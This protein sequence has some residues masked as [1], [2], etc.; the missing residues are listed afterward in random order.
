MSK[1]NF[2]SIDEAFVLGSEQI[3][4]TQDEIANLKKIIMDSSISGPSNSGPSNSGPSN[5]GPVINSIPK[6][7]YE[8]IGPPDRT[9][10]NFEK[11]DN[12]FNFENNF[13]K[14]I[15]HPRFD[16]LVYKYVHN[17]Y[18]NWILR[19]KEY[20]GTKS[21]FGNNYNK[22]STTICSDIKNYLIFFTVSIAI[23]LLLSLLVKQ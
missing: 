11:G 1:L 17:N 10:V 9:Q 21:N 13:F 15:Q 3:K 8:R 23:Y 22:Y 14:M 5:S 6:N 19:D 16:D 7:S 2:S 12:E 18:P 4:N 20:T